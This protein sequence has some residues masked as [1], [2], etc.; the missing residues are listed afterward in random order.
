[1]V[2]SLV[3]GLRAVIDGGGNVAAGLLGRGLQSADGGGIAL[4]HW[5]DHA[6]IV[7]VLLLDHPRTFFDRFVALV[8]HVRYDGLQFLDVHEYS[9][10]YSPVSSMALHPGPLPFVMDATASG[11]SS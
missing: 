7:G 6:D 1:M 3:S 5:M 8:R 9:S 11:V 4:R 10:L 2:S